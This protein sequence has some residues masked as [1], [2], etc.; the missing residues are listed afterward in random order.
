MRFL[1]WNMPYHTAHHV[2]PVVPFHRL[3]C[4]TALLESRLATTADG[5]VDAHRRIRAAW[6]R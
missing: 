2:L 3:G 4:L 5:Y 6:E 1:A